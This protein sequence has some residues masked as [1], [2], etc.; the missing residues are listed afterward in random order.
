MFRI[1]GKNIK[2]PS[3]G[4]ANQTMKTCANV[5]SPSM[6]MNTPRACYCTTNNN[7]QPTPPMAT[8]EDVLLNM[9]GQINYLSEVVSGQQPTNQNPA[10][11]SSSPSGAPTALPMKTLQSVV[12]IFC[13]NSSPNFGMP[14]QRK[15]QT[16]VTGSGFVLDAKEKI[17]VTNAHVVAYAAFVEVRRHGGSSKYTAEMVYIA[18]DC[19]IAL[20]SVEDPEF[21]NGIEA[22]EMEGVNSDD[23]AAGSRLN[24]VAN[25]GMFSGLPELQQSV[26]VVG[27]PWGGDQISITSGVVS[28]IDSSPYGGVDVFLMA[29]QIDAAINPGNSGGPALCNNRVV[30]IAFQ[31]L[32]H[33]DNIGYIIPIPVIAHALRHYLSCKNTHTTRTVRYTPGHYHPGFCGLGIL[34]Q[35]LH[36]DTLRDFFKVP[37]SVSGVLVQEIMPCS[38]AQGFLLEDDVIVAVDSHPVGNDGTVQWRGNERVRFSHIFQMKNVGDR[39]Q[40]NIIRQGQEKTLSLELQVNESLVPNTLLTSKHLERPQF[41]VFGGCVFTQ[42]TFPLLLEWGPN[43]WVNNAPRH[44]V[45]LLSSGRV[46][47]TRREIVVLQQ[48]LPHK[49][50]KGYVSDMFNFR[51]ITHCN[52]TEVGSLQHLKQMLL[53]ASDTV[54]L[55]AV[56]HHNKCTLI[57]PVGDSKHADNEIRSLYN[58]PNTEV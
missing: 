18:A 4:V 12:K 35:E 7:N 17:I 45:E 25:V 54:R 29:I 10:P 19:D 52:G 40:A 9:Q 33:G 2:H 49:V 55:L 5:F 57:L 11:H 37:K 43:E 31:V 28:R 36:N 21:W 42:L 20:L 53:E 46:T 48:M 38:R 3:F 41:F 16:I 47:K 50:N 14:W 56:N 44:L 24:A 34:V 6:M 23:V 51:I 32:S 30:G 22:L 27:Y 1:L 8:L 58:I 13:T 26:K 15:Q 39:I